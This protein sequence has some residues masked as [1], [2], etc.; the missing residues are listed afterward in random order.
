MSFFFPVCGGGLRDQQY[1]PFSSCGSDTHCDVGT[2]A[3]KDL[4]FWTPG[5]HNC[6]HFSSWGGG[7]CEISICWWFLVGFFS[8]F[9]VCII[10]WLPYK[11]SWSWWQP[12]WWSHLF[13]REWAE[14]IHHCAGITEMVSG[15]S[16]SGSLELDWNYSPRETCT[17]ILSTQQLFQTLVST[18]PCQAADSHTGGSGCFMCG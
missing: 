16:S 15:S 11:R 17:F 7:F 13:I 3:H 18:Q 9:S 6:P 2:D 14:A 5:S 12:S 8:L 4:L 10:L 1:W